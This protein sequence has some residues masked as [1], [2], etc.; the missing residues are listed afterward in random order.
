MLKTTAL[1]LFAAI[2]IL[3]TISS[4]PA[5]GT[6]DT[7]PTQAAEASESACQRLLGP[8]KMAR[9]RAATW[10]AGTAASSAEPRSTSATSFAAASQRVDGRES[11]SSAER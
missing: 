10:T 3:C 9:P 4:R 7:T 11:A 8:R 2:A 1:G 6:L 5:A